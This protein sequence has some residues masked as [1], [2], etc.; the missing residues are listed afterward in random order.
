MGAEESARR[1]WS[2]FLAA[3]R[4]GDWYSTMA[5]VL[6]KRRWRREAK[7]RNS[8]GGGEGGG[9]V[10]FG[11]LTWCCRRGRLGV[12]AVLLKERWHWQRRWR[13]DIYAYEFEK[14]SAIQQ[15]V[16]LPIIKG[17][18]VITQAQSGT[19]KTSMS[20]SP[21]A[22]WSTP[23]P[24]F[25]ASPSPPYSLSFRLRHLMLLLELIF[26]EDSLGLMNKAPQV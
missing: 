10:L 5:V 4:D 15:R 24:E 12:A 8:F 26:V 16:V 14:L 6:S 21:Y 17:R 9:P 3:A 7:W 11:A 1:W 20:P 18:G 19:E 2:S 13:R 23:P 22:R 25:V